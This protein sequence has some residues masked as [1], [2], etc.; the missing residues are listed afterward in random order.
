MQIIDGKLVS[1]DT[2]K[3]NLR[4]LILHH[5]G[6]ESI[7]EIIDHN[8]NNLIYEN[9]YELQKTTKF[10][11]LFIALLAELSVSLEEDNFY[12]QKLD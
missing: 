10:E 1:F 3:I 9:L 4:E 6:A 5:F 11:D 8:I 2:T 7:Q 12:Y